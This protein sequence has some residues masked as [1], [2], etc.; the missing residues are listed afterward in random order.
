V[1][2]S[3]SGAEHAQAK[4]SGPLRKA[5]RLFARRPGLAVH[6]GRVAA[7]GAVSALRDDPTLGWLGSAGDVRRAAPD[8]ILGAEW[9]GLDTFLAV[10]R[11]HLKPEDRVLEIGAGGGRVTRPLAEMAATVAATDVSDAIL[12]EARH[13]A[14]MPNV[15]FWQVTGFGDNLH[16]EYE[17]VVSHDVFVHFELDETARY[18]HNIRRVLALG[19]LLIVSV[20]T[21]DGD[22]EENQ[23]VEAIAGGTLGARRVR[24]FPS[25]VYETLFKA[26][27][28]TVVEAVRTPLDEYSGKPFGHLNF[29]ARL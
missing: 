2:D 21:I 9:G 11:E 16:G 28:F 13:H 12:D 19:G 15:T 17:A 23:Y 24:R 18:L 6:A 29:V 27:G 14:S 3:L 8:A 1:R 5:A 7:S 22:T 25:A 4:R 10:L 26:F 20:Y